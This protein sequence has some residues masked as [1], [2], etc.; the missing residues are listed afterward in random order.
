MS[1]LLF[2]SFMLLTRCH[3]QYAIPFVISI[4][5]YWRNQRS[6]QVD[7]YVPTQRFETLPLQVAY[8]V[9]RRSFYHLTQSRFRGLIAAAF[10]S[11]GGLL[12]S[13]FSAGTRSTYICP[14]VLHGAS[15]LRSY[16]MF[17]LFADSVILIGITELCRIGT[18]FDDVRRKRTL[19]FL[20]AG[21]LVS[22]QLRS[23]WEYL[24]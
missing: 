17:N 20:G 2:K 15:R 14:I 19:T 18:Q 13:S 1:W 22:G 10:L 24:F 23:C 3:G 8:S 5:D 16:R 4:Y 12:A 11:V 6:R 21:L 7:R 9:S